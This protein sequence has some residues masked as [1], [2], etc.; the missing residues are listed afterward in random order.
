MIGIGLAL[1][2][3]CSLGWVAADAL[4]KRLSEG[5]SAL[6]VAIGLHLFQLPIIAITLLLSET[7]TTG[8][9]A[10][11][12]IS[13][14][15]DSS[16]WMLA[17]PSI[18]CNAI[19]NLL[20]VRALQL[21]DLSLT[22]PYLSLTPVLALFTSWLVVGE[23]PALMGVVGVMIIAFGALVLNPNEKD[24][25]GFHPIR[26]LLNERGS[27]A[28]LGVAALWSISVSFDKRALEYASPIS[29]TTILAVS[30]AIIL[31]FVR[32]R[33]SP[34]TIWSALKPS[35]GLM[36]VTT[37]VV[38]VALLAQLWAYHY[39]PVAYVEAIK[40]SIGMLG[41]V[42]VG[43]WMFDESSI[44]RRLVAV[45]VMGLGVCLILLSG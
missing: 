21:S 33:R 2:I 11:D 20:F 40:R 16:Y 7:S 23:V 17:A 4:R 12:V 45:S 41:A 32:Q 18:I 30:G 34:V 13:W 39:T 31:E 42:A 38:F 5:L 9:H 27:L 44:Y 36:G 35:A 28:M 14:S 37:V 15:L 26:A 43:W 1:T 24:R 8:D 25:G 19:A 3:G 29:H 6:E 10:F 22:I